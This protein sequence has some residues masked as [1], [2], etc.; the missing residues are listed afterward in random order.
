MSEIS[1]ALVNIADSRKAA[2]NRQRE[3]GGSDTGARSEVTSGTHMDELTSVIAQI[4]VDAGIPED[5][6]FSGRSG[7]ELPGFFVLRRNGI[8]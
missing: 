4:F 2:A 7:L 5:C 6:V 8:L 1:Y 3:S